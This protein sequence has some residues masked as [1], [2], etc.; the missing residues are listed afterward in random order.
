MKSNPLQAYG[1]IRVSSEEQAKSG[2]SLSGQKRKIEAYAKL[3]DI[4][5]IKVIQDSAISAKNTEREGLQELLKAVE[6]REIQAVIVYKL[7]RLS[8]S[9]IDTLNLISSFEKHNV[10]FHSIQEKID[11][12]SALGRFFL[13]ITAAFAQMERDT[14]S[15]R[16]AFALKEKRRQGKR[17]GNIPFGFD[18]ASDKQTLLENSNEQKAI[19]LILRL[20][21]KN[22]SLRKIAFELAKKGLKPKHSSKWHPKVIKSI[23]SANY[24]T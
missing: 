8:R 11:T 2:L 18:L 19:K 10:A 6:N 22:L 5:L 16:T 7:D 1:Y 14:I 15:E 3:T 9:V 4:D 17:A 20:H 13:T 12:K 23:I 21:S 24:A